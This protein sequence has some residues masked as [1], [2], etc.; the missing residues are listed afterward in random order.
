MEQNDG[1]AIAGAIQ[2][3]VRVGTRNGEHLCGMRWIGS[4]TGLHSFMRT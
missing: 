4:G 1:G 2:A 3:D